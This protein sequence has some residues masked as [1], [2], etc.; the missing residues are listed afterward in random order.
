MRNHWSSMGSAFD[1]KNSV[2]ANG[3]DYIAIYVTAAANDVTFDTCTFTNATHVSLGPNKGSDAVGLINVNNCTF[4]DGGCLSGYFETL[5]VT[6]T[7]V[8]AAKNGFINKSKAG[9]VTVTDCTYGDKVVA[10]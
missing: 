2:E 8:T 7:T 3:E 5:N 1:A 6:N 9:N 4:N 10:D